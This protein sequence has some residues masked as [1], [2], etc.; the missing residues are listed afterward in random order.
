MTRIKREIRA[1]LFGYLVLLVLIFIVGW[2]VG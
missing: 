2:A 1:A